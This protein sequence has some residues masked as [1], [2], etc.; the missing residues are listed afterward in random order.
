MCFTSMEDK[1][2]SQQKLNRKRYFDNEADWFKSYDYTTHQ[3]RKLI[4]SLGLNRTGLFALPTS[5]TTCLVKISRTDAWII[6]L[7][8]HYKNQHWALLEA[9]PYHF[10]W[11]AVTRRFRPQLNRWEIVKVCGSSPSSWKT[12]EYKMWTNLYNSNKNQARRIWL[13]PA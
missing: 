10:N 7:F 9:S 3:N 5:A 13:R 2:K 6:G 1:A 11:V 12:H 8:E 4:E